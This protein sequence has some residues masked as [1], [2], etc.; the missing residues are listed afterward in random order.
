MVC[1]AKGGFDEGWCGGG[2]LGDARGVEDEAGGIEPVAEHVDGEDGVGVLT[3]MTGAGGGELIGRGGAWGTQG[4]AFLLGRG[5]RTTANPQPGLEGY[6]NDPLLR[7]S[8]VRWAW[9]AIDSLKG[10]LHVILFKDTAIG[11]FGEPGL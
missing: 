3:P 5:Y 10:M 11:A 4:V 2:E 9:R 7:L 6:F 8:L 1:G